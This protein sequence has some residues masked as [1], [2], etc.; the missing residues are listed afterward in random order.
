MPYDYINKDSVNGIY[1]IYYGN[2]KSVV[3]LLTKH[4]TCPI[5]KS[6]INAQVGIHMYVDSVQRLFIEMQSACPEWFIYRPV[7][8]QCL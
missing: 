2:V 5:D 6:L 1:F 3:L 8:L 4:T 7:T